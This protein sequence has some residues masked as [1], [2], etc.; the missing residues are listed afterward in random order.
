LN[1]YLDS[2]ALV[3]LV[4]AESES[5]ALIKFLDSCGADHFVTSALSGVEVA[6]ATATAGSEAQAQ[7]RDQLASIDFIAVDDDV[8]LR[9]TQLFPGERLRTL[10]AIHIASAQMVGLSLESIVT[11]DQG[12]TDSARRLGFAVVQPA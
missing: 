10:D 5:P 4:I 11:Y 7:A 12:M 8:L 3:K 1:I 2:S 6:R 9:A